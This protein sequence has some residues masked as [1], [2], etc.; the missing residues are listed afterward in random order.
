MKT[1]VFV[2][3]IPATTEGGVHPKRAAIQSLISQLSNLSVVS[4][5]TVETLKTYELPDDVLEFEV[6]LTATKRAVAAKPA[7]KTVQFSKK[8][9]K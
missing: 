8:N 6:T 3:N 1:F 5:E 9:K 2:A 4:D 7:E